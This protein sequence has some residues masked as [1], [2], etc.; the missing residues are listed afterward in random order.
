MRSRDVRRCGER[1]GQGDERAE[2]G[3]RETAREKSEHDVLLRIFFKR[4]GSKKR[5]T[6][7]SISFAAE[8]NL[9]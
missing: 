7:R 2:R 6:A 5:T 8:M 9:R 1:R 3:E 4:G